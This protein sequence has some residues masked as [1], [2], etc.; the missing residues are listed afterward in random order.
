M[1]EIQMYP[2]FDR[3]VLRS[4]FS[5]LST[6]SFSPQR[7]L[8]TTWIDLYAFIF[9]LPEKT[10]G[11]CPFYSNRFQVKIYD[12]KAGLFRQMTQICPDLN[13]SWV[14]S[15]N[16]GQDANWSTFLPWGQFTCL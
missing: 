11:S 4:W 16:L 2:R 13:N 3:F 6:R 5:F 1:S 8:T 10:E 12:W 15:I 7:S 14:T 9:L